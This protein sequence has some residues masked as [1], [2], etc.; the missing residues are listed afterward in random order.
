MAILL[1]LI[2]FLFSCSDN[3]LNNSTDN[4][5]RVK[6]S[7][8]KSKVY[9]GGTL[10][11]SLTDKEDSI[12]SCKWKINDS[13]IGENSDTIKLALISPG[14]VQLSCQARFMSDSLSEWFDTTLS[15][16]HSQE[17]RISVDETKLMT[18]SDIPF[19]LLGPTENFKECYWTVGDSSFTTDTTE[20]QYRFSDSGKVAVTAQIV[21]KDG[22]KSSIVKENVS[23]ELGPIPVLISISASLTIDGYYDL[24]INNLSDDTLSLTVIT[25]QITEDFLLP[26][27]GVKIFYSDIGLTAGNYY[28]IK[29]PGFMEHSEMLV[30]P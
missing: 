13:L 8:D 9:V 12:E 28:T 10:L 17:L 25:D 15:V 6:L 3:G 2:L 14:T 29:G 1:L 27:N 19:S 4:T 26:P 5:Q 23:I 11:I 18:H 20:M 21:Y 16:T 7:F 24:T 22:K 30:V